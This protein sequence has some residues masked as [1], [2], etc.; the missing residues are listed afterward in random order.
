MDADHERE[1]AWLIERY[2]NSRIHYFDGSPRQG[3]HS[4]DFSAAWNEKADAAIRFA[5]EQD[6]AVVLARC[7]GGIGRVAEHAF[8]PTNTR[9]PEDRVN[10]GDAAIEAVSQ[11]YSAGWLDAIQR[12]PW[13]DMHDWLALQAQEYARGKP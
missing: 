11:A 12:K 10:P 6:A 8:P 2:H 4:A 3:V 1:T 5:R 9:A 7:L 13:D